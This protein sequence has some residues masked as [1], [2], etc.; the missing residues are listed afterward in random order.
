MVVEV[1]VRF[2]SYTWKEERGTSELDILRAERRQVYS[3][4]TT[5]TVLIRNMKQEESNPITIFR[6]KDSEERS[7]AQKN[8]DNTA[9]L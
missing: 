4:V 5:A 7:A 9:L 8:N 2:A 3:E 1:E 6:G